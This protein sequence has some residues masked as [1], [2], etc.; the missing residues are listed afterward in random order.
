VRS[1]IRLENR[2]RDANTSA[3]GDVAETVIQQHRQEIAA[4]APS[5]PLRYALKL[6]LNELRSLRRALGPVLERRPHVRR[7]LEA[8][9]EY[10]E[11]GTDRHRA[12]RG[13]EGRQGNG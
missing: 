12:R 5:D 2:R 7:V 13:R 3:P 9:I 6:P 8:I 11:R 4:L 1:G 10:K